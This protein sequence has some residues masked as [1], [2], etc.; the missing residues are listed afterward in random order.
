[1][2]SNHIIIPDD[3]INYSLDQLSIPTHY[4]DYIEGIMIPHGLILDRVEKLAQEIHKDYQEK[5]IHILCVLKGG[6]KIFADLTNTLNI[7]NSRY[8]NHGIPITQDFIKA[9]SYINTK[10]SGQVNVTKDNSQLEQLRGKDVLLVE[11][12]IDTGR[13][14][15]ALTDLISEYSPNSL[16][17]LSLLVKRIKESNGFTPDY[18]GFSIPDKF[19]VG[20][21][22]DFNE[23]FRDLQHICVIN[24]KGIEKYKK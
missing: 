21:C 7:L 5:N 18:V 1:M 6:E 2:S 19:V 8:N 3:N 17:V 15:K 14:I 22:L 11:D 4:H 10:T 9:S 24:S 20:Y 23:H 12:I 13:T 16:R